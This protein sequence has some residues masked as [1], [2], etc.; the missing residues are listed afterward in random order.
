MFSFKNCSEPFNLRQS[1]M[2]WW[3]YEER[4]RKYEV[5]R[6]Q[7]VD[8][9]A[10]I[11]KSMRD[12]YKTSPAQLSGAQKTQLSS[13]NPYSRHRQVAECHKRADKCDNKLIKEGIKELY[14]PPRTLRD[15]HREGREK[16]IINF[17]V[18]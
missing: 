1:K 5:T 11:G 12:L 8:I 15:E 2:A 14:M 13:Q 3:I 10:G 4:I 16:F 17:N 9:T 6:L 7:N 18:T